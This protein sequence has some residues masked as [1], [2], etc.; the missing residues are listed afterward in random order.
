MRMFQ[1]QSMLI[2]KSRLST[3]SLDVLK[4][5]MGEQKISL[6]LK[7]KLRRLNNISYGFLFFCYLKF[8]S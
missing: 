2:N 4:V 7:N 5:Y 6:H 8:I 3:K 1:T